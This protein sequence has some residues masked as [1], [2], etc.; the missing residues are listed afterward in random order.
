MDFNGKTVW[1]VPTNEKQNTLLASS[2]KPHGTYGPQMQ[3]MMTDLETRK[4]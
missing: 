2:K 3:Q 4:K 1:R